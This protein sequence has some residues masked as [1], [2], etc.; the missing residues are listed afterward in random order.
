MKID[1]KWSFSRREKYHLRE[2]RNRNQ[3]GLS[4]TGTFARLVSVL[5]YFVVGQK[6][7]FFLTGC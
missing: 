2:K 5:K 3:R 4:T 6:W 1:N 7:F